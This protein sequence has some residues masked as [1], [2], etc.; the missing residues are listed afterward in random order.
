MKNLWWIVPVCVI[1][2]AIIISIGTSAQ[3]YV[4]MLEAREEE[5]LAKHAKLERMM[6][7]EMGK[8]MAVRDLALCNTVALREAGGDKASAWFAECIGDVGD[9]DLP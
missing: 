7:D 2:G 9:K 8:R 6:E 5:H 1:A 3:D 4:L